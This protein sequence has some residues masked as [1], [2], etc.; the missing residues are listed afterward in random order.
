MLEK[1]LGSAR[2]RGEPRNEAPARAHPARRA[3]PARQGR[4]V[5]SRTCSASAPNDYDARAARRAAARDRR[6]P[7]R[8]RRGCS[9]PS[10]SRADEVRDLVRVLEIRLRALDEAR[11]ETGPLDDERKDL[12]RRIAQL[13][14]DRLHDDAGALD[15]LV[16][17][18]AG[19]AARHGR[20]RSPPRDRQAARRAGDAS[21]TVLETA[22]DR[23]DT[24][25]MRGE[26]L[27]EVARIYEEQLGNAERAE[28]T[29]RKV[30]ETRSRRRGAGA[31]RRRARS[32]ASTSPP[33]RTRSFATRSRRRSAS[34]PSTSARR[35]LEGRLGTLCETF[36]DDADGAIAAWKARLEENSA[37][38]AALAALD[39]LY[40]KT[41]RNRE[42]VQILESRRDRAEVPAERR[43]LMR[44]AAETLVRE[45]RRVLGRHRR[46]A[47]H[48][49]ASSARAPKRSSRSR[50]CTPPA[51]SA[52]DLADAY[53]AHLDIVES[54]PRSPRAAREAR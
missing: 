39:R 20:A 3:A 2:R 29:Y 28:A 40:E 9:R 6:S 51:L 10:T 17:L 22:S 53:E 11:G 52:T 54:E 27:T 7:D 37:D 34:N 33:E 21:R 23:A 38:D 26:I 45:A 30:L 35:E 43:E 42:L 19:G 48:R 32:S 36:L 49:R 24:P 1:R 12:L 25:G 16:A 14:D 31:S 46:V 8:A 15:A 50:R 18:R 4:V 13:R 5:T 41:G 44:R 47:R